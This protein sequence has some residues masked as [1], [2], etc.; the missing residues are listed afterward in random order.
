MDS[1]VSV[2]V[3]DQIEN[4]ERELLNLP[5][6]ECPLKHNFAPGVYMREITM[7]AGSLII[8]H[9]HLTEHFNVV[10]TGKARVMI[11]GV[12]EDL[13]APCYFISKPNVRKVLYIVEEMKFATIHPT[14]ETSVEVLENTLIRKSNSFIKHEEA[15]ALLENPSTKED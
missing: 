6:V 11:D 14:D 9:E 3:N 1:L 2:P 10:L 13:V 4:L 15:K 12:I 7:P 5:Q 8:G